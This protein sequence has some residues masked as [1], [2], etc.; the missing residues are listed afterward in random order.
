MLN[1]GILYAFG[2]YF[3]WGLVPIYWKLLK[4]VPATQLIGHRIVWSFI[5]LA[6]ILFV[7]RKWPELRTAVSNRQGDPYLLCRGSA[8]RFQLVHLCLGSDC[9]LYRGVQPGIFYQSAPQCAPGSHLSARTFA[10]IPVDL[11]RPGCRRS[12]LSHC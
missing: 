6:V 5:L 2:A 7:M 4:H 12:D 11:H 10:L 3:I 1:K 8:V 9:R